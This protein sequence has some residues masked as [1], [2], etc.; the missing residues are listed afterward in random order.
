MRRRLRTQWQE[1]HPATQ[2]WLLCRWQV[3]RGREAPGHSAGHGAPDFFLQM[4]TPHC[5]ASTKTLSSTLSNCIGG[6]LYVF[7]SCKLLWKLLCW[8]ELAAP[9]KC[10]LVGAETLLGGK[11]QLCRVGRQPCFPVCQ[12]SLCQILHPFLSC[13]HTSPHPTPSRDIAAEDTIG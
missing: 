3:L 9:M 10:E 1:L 12:G 4:P 2:L 13:T 8:L 5:K 7:L 11:C 6:A